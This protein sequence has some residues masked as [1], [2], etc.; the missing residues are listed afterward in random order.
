MN[1][2]PHVSVELAEAYPP[3]T[4]QCRQCGYVIPPEEYP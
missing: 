2:C 1:D 4:L 3:G